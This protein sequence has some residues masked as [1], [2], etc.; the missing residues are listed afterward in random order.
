MGYFARTT[1]ATG[2]TTSTTDQV[3]FTSGSANVQSRTDTDVNNVAMHVDGDVS[4]TGKLH[5][6]EVEAD[7]ILESSDPRKKTNME[8]MDAAAGQT[9]L[10]IKPFFYELKSRPGELHT[11]VD[12]AQVK[13]LAPHAVSMS[14][15]GDLAVNYRMISMHMLREL[16]TQHT[17]IMAL[18]RQVAGLQSNT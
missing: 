10:L 8:A 16:Q 7:T 14:K 9:A 18:Q 5:I 17:K 12:A 2:A 1:V 4:C 15:K 3:Q 11:G 6:D 13:K